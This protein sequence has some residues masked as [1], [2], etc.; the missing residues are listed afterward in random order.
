MHDYHDMVVSVGLSGIPGE[1]QRI[2]FK[3]PGGTRGYSRGVPSVSLSSSATGTC[4]TGTSVH[5][6]NLCGVPVK[7]RALYEMSCFC[8]PPTPQ[9]GKGIRRRIKGFSGRVLGPEIIWTYR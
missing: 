3:S 2:R 6:A 8:R 4:R 1:S 7:V 5:S 9:L